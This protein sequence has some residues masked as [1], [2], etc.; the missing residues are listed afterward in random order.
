MT[1]PPDDVDGWL[2]EILERF[3]VASMAGVGQGYDRDPRQEHWV[4]YLQRQA[5]EHALAT[6]G[7]READ[8]PPERFE[9]AMDVIEGIAAQLHQDVPG[10]GRSVVSEAQVFL[11]FY[12]AAMV[13][14]DALAPTAAG[15][16]ARACWAGC[17]N[18]DGPDE[19]PTAFDVADAEAEAPWPVMMKPPEDPAGWVEELI[20]AYGNS[21]SVPP[22]KID[23]GRY[24]ARRGSLLEAAVV[25][26]LANRGVVVPC[27]EVRDLIDAIFDM[28]ADVKRR[29]PEWEQMQ[30]IRPLAFVMYY[31]WVHLAIGCLD[32]DHAE[33]IVAACTAKLADFPE[34][35]RKAKRDGRPTDKA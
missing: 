11:L 30:A 16:L 15:V 4:E 28:E 18:Q 25:L 5:V 8:A 6:H 22:L 31:I 24:K 19:E 33:R 29:G 23:T 12:L 1:L 7:L 2:K 20:V 3:E 17:A 9:A 34:P 10:G 32:E 27:H 13:Q 26:A 21:A 35:V 14:A